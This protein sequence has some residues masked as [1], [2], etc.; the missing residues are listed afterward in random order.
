MII[1]YIGDYTVKC[2][3]VLTEE[4]HDFDTAHKTEV[5]APPPDEWPPLHLDVASIKASTNIRET[6]C[7]VSIR[8]WDVLQ[9][10]H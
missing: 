8:F 5:G 4:D 3:S 10:P 9:A 2:A 6:F 1:K 7:P